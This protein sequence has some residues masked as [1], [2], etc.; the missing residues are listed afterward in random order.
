VIAHWSFHKSKAHSAA[1]NVAIER[2]PL[3]V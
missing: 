1:L 2:V 3:D